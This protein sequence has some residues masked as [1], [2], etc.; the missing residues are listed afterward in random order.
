M[1]SAGPT[2]HLGARVGIVGEQR[3]FL[4]R[5]CPARGVL[6][7]GAAR[8]LPA[9]RGRNEQ[10]R[11]QGH[12][13][14]SHGW[15]MLAQVRLAAYAPMAAPRGPRPAYARVAPPPGAAGAAAP[16]GPVSAR[17]QRPITVSAIRKISARITNHDHSSRP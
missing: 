3:V 14:H 10:R 1:T 9:G 8:V 6:G 11:A 4:R 2:T 15:M 16:S 5:G 7:R 12:S 13:E 17:P